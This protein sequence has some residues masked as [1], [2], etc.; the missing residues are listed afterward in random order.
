MN[1][2]N[3]SL[4]LIRC[5][6]NSLYTGITT[7]VTRRFSEHTEGKTGAK[8]L[9]GKGPLSLVFHKVVGNRSEASKMEIKVKKLSKSEK[10]KL[11]LGKRSLPSISP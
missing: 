10:E 1:K 3:W 4:Y 5:K 11:I 6:D 2:D 8:Y 9:R 7:D